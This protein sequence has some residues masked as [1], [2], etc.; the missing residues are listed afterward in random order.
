MTRGVPA[1]DEGAPRPLQ[2][3]VRV[4]EVRPLARILLYRVKYSFMTSRFSASSAP[5]PRAPAVQAAASITFSMCDSTHVGCECNL[6]LPQSPYL[7]SLL[8]GCVRICGTDA[9]HA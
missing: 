3:G 2:S 7:Q 1:S 6:N 8:Q 4:G 9:R 5:S